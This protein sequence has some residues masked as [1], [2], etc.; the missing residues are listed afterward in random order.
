[1]DRMVS[2]VFTT[3]LVPAPLVAVIVIG[4]LATMVVVRP[5]IRPA[6]FTVSP[7]GRPTTLKDCGVFR[8]APS[9]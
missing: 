9:N 7:V 1:M 2:V 6:E 8:M 3:A 5:L 4:L